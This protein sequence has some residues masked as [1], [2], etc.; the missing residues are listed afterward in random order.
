MIKT[1]DL[2]DFYIKQGAR[3]V[4]GE[5][6][7]FIEFDNCELMLTYCMLDN[8]HKVMQDF[9]FTPFS[10]G[11]YE[12]GKHDLLLINATDEDVTVSFADTKNGFQLLMEVRD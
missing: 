8:A 7:V 1:Q 5:C 3:I 11:T 9:D 2:I 12:K 6:D 4:Q 10:G